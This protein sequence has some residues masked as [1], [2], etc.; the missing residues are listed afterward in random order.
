[1]PQGTDEVRAADGTSCRSAVGGNGAYVDMGMVGKQGVADNGA[2]YGRVVVPLGKGS[3]RLDCSRLYELEVERLKL[4]LELAKAGL[5]RQQDP[6]LDQTETSAVE[7]EVE[8][9]HSD[10]SLAKKRA[11]ERVGEE[12][13]IEDVEDTADVEEPVVE[14]PV[15]KKKAKKVAAAEE[16]APANAKKKKAKKVGDADWANEGWSTDGRQ[17]E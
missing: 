11:Q 17:A 1:M 13:E 16:A 14:Q 2:Y 3:K 15:K 10:A 9:S 12:E 8:I 5:G 6:T 7:E 4:E